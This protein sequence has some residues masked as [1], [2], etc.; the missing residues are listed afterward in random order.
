M[1]LTKT[2][3][4][5]EVQAFVRALDTQ[6]RRDF[7]PA[8]GRHA[9]VWAANSDANLSPRVWRL[10]LWDEP[11]GPADAG[12]FGHHHHDGKDVVPVGHVFV[13]VCRRH[14]ERWTEI[15]SHEALEMLG[16]EWINLDVARHLVNGDVELWPRE[17]C[18]AV[19][20]QRY[21]IDGVTVS[22][23]VLPEYFIENADGPYDFLRKL[24]R[25]F[26]IAPTGYSAILR[27][28][29]K[30]RAERRNIY[31]AKYPAWRK[32][33]RVGSRRD[34]RFRGALAK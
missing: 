16:D 1:N 30:G 9:V 19:Q 10:Y 12:A 18:D 7:T 24:D 8:W 15:A 23:F 13:E 22:N 25:P 21:E 6:I 4:A 3:K 28:T 26:A 14:K 27:I 31:G 5:E 29:P 2:L 17:L 20:G 11:R 33:D 32:S 34:A